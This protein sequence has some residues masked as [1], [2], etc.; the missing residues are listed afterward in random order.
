MLPEQEQTLYIEFDELFSL[1]ERLRVLADQL[2]SQL[3][4]AGLRE[5]LDVEIYDSEL[6]LRGVEGSNLLIRLDSFR[7]EIAG[8]RPDVALHNLAALVLAQAEVFRLTS[9][10]VGFTA[11]LKA[12]PGRPLNLVAQAF[13]PAWGLRDEEQLDRRFAM[14]WDWASPTTGYSFHASVLEDQELML[15]FKAREGYMTLLELQSGRWMQE[16]RLRFQQA[17]DLFLTLLGWNP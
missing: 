13:D 14:T 7:L 1:R 3:V 5:R 4:A 17:A 9:V 8:V 6:E 11:W 16:Q 15:S 10:E 2:R 12:G